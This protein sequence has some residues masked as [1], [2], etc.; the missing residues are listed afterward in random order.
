MARGW[1][2]ADP[3]IGTY[4]NKLFLHGWQGHMGHQV[5]TDRSLSYGAQ[6][7]RDRLAADFGYDF[8][9]GRQNLEH[10]RI[11]HQFGRRQAE[12]PCHLEGGQ[13]LG[14]VV[15]GFGIGRHALVGPHG[16]FAGIVGGQNHQRIIVELGQQPVEIGHPALDVLHR[17]GAVGDAK[18]FG[19]G[20]NQLHQA[21]SAGMADGIFLARAFD[22]HHGQDQRGRDLGSDRGAQDVLAIDLGDGLHRLHPRRSDLR[23]RGP[24]DSAAIAAG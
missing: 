20:G 15:A 13:H 22:A 7:V 18:A 11:G 4:P 23:A 14:H 3:F 21:D 17:I 8:S 10:A 24:C 6:A 2:F 5:W 16:T 19:G 12:A 1:G 9:P